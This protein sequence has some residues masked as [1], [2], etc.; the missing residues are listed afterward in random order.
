MMCKREK[1]IRVR[2]TEDALVGVLDKRLVGSNTGGRHSLRKRWNCSHE[3]ILV[4]VKKFQ[5]RKLG[6]ETDVQELVS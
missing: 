5:R 1:S 6:N 2:R 4:K 3:K